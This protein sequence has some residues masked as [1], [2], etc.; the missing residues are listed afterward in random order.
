MGSTVLS[1]AGL[2]MW[3]VLAGALVGAEASR[4]TWCGRREEAYLW[5]QGLVS[6]FSSGPWPTLEG[7]AVPWVLG[8]LCALLWEAS[9]LLVWGLFSAQIQRRVVASCVQCAAL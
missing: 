8:R 2:A 1:P 6:R 3:C 5:G 7:M 9:G 4:S